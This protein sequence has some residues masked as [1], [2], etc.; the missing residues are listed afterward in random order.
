M[1]VSAQP[2][3]NVSIASAGATTFPYGFKILA[4][5]H[6]RV[7]VDGED[8][9]AGVH[10][11]V[12][13]A[14]A[15]GGG[16]I[17]F[18]SPMA[19]GEVVVC[20]RKMTYTRASDSQHF[21]DLYSPAIDSNQNAR[22]LMIQ[23]VA[24]DTGVAQT[25]QDNLSASASVM[26]F[27]A[28]G[29]WDGTSGTDDS[30]AF[31]NAIDAMA[32][33]GGGLVKVPSASGGKAYR[34]DKQVW[35]KS[36]V[37]LIGADKLQ[38]PNF[39]SA[40]INTMYGGS[41]LAITWGAGSTGDPGT[42]TSCAIRMSPQTTVAGLNFI[43]PG[44]VTTL[45]ASAPVM[46]PP[47]ISGNDGDCP[48]GAIEDCYFVNSYK[49][50]YIPYAHGELRIRSVWGQIIEKFFTIN[51]CYNADS[52]YDC[53]LSGIFYL[54]D[55]PDANFTNNSG[56][57]AW[58]Q[59]HGMG[60]DIGY[61]DA[62]TWANCFVGN[63]LTAVHFGNAPSGGSTAGLNQ[64][65][66]GSWIGGGIE[67]VTFPFWVEGSATSG[68]NSNGFRV[69]EAG[70]APIGLFNAS[71]A[72]ALR[73]TQP[74]G[75]YTDSSDYRGKISFSNC[76]FWGIGSWSVNTGPLEGAAD[77]S[78]GDIDFHGCTFK[79]FQ[80][81]IA[82]S[83][84]GTPIFRFIGCS[85]QDYPALTPSYYHFAAN[86]SAGGQFLHSACEFRKAQRTFYGAGAT[87]YVH[88]FSVP[89]VASASTVTIP[90]YS[91]FISITGTT[92]V[93]SLAPSWAGRR[94]SLLFAAS[95][96]VSDGNNLKL[97][98]P[99]SAN[100]DDT[101]SLVSDGTNWIEISRSPN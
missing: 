71:R 68:L 14:G 37:R 85:F 88:G 20:S 16:H 81:Y 70:I 26:D 3:R 10:Y 96:T 63:C 1:T 90:D 100:A 29:D 7:Q 38:I 82:R 17:T 62:I 87:A 73:M 6:L 46:F 93:N 30:A 97:N 24:D 50:V 41:C 54:R 36:G 65:A 76:E 2:P 59:T 86:A 42:N 53:N 78:G 55:S 5:S 92:N 31:Q 52:F 28:K 57:W 94:I 22:N 23:Q 72:V 98:G 33:I 45:N 101:L 66:Y 48:G 51:G 15:E 56:L 67:A 75:G 64:H 49:A 47:T 83:F 19:G 60:W 9:K 11:S 39:Y 12:N 35:V 58:I 40:S 21:D 74:T 99:F 32:A 4:D 27:G 69:A 18:S 95:L 79:A 80:N 43:Y 8:K 89:V 84:S 34:L 77:A 25:A 44:Q 91:D 13:G 61:A